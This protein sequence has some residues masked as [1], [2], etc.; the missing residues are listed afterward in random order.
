VDWRAGGAPLAPRPRP[1]GASLCFSK[2]RLLHLVLFVPVVRI[3]C[4]A[5]RKPFNPQTLI[6]HLTNSNGCGNLW[7]RFCKRVPVSSL[8]LPSKRRVSAPSSRQPTKFLRLMRKLFLL[9]NLRTLQ[10][11]C[12]SFSRSL[13][14][15]STVCALFCK[16]A[17]GGGWASRS[18]LWTLG[19]SRRRLP[20][21][22]MLL[23]DTRGGGYLSTS[24]PC[25]PSPV[26]CTTCAS[27][28]CGVTRLR[29]LPVTTG[30]YPNALSAFPANPIGS[31]LT[32]FV[33][34]RNTAFHV[35]VSV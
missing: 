24:V 31:P 7:L 11:S 34:P 9:N 14:L 27:I 32:R 10:L 13:P 22:E 28:P 26:V 1:G 8:L 35:G 6:S 2:V 15:F 25:V 12:G 4:T 20:V 16:N 18:G 29:I 3:R 17:G 21:P 23:R 33:H 19:G 30:V 5:P